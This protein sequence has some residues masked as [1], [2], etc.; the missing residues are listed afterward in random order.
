[1]AGGAGNS[2]ERFLC[3]VGIGTYS[4]WLSSKKLKARFTGRPAGNFSADN[5]RSGGGLAGEPQAPAASPIPAAAAAKLVP[6]LNG[7]AVVAGEAFAETAEPGVVRAG[8]AARGEGASPRRRK[9]AVSTYLRGASLPLFL[10]LRS[11]AGTD[12]D[13]SAARHNGRPPDTAR[14]EAPGCLGV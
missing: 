14:I 6:G 13:T 12:R 4:V 8:V 7:A 11:P 10:L 1:M 2:P 5:G 9:P 3:A